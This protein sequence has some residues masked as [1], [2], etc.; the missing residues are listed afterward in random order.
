MTHYVKY[1]RTLHLPWSGH[2]STDD[3]MLDSVEHFL[4][5]HVVV[6]EKMDGENTTMYADYIHARSINSRHHDSRNWVK[7]LHGEV[8]SDIPYGF[9]V[10]GENLYAKHSIAYSSLPSY[11]LMFSIWHKDEC[12]TWDE[13]VDWADLL[14]LQTVPVLYEGLWNEAEIRKCWTGTSRYGVEQE[15]YVVRLA[16][17]FTIEQFPLS[18]AKYVRPDHIQTDEHW[19]TSAIVHNELGDKYA[20]RSTTNE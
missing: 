11:F 5:K 1:P 12:L 16:D 4:G 7:G 10:S 15:G 2:I 14:G 19:M 13:T 6:T 9:R 17:R 18:V 8:C 3:K 20:I